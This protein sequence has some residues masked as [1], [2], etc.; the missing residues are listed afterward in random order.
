[1]T[2]KSAA[3]KSAKAW[4]LG[5]VLPW[6]LIVAG[7][8]GVVCAFVITM[9]KFQILKDP[10]YVVSCDINPVISCGSVMRSDQAEAFGFPNPIIGLIGFPVLITIGVAMLAGATFKRWFWIV[11]QLGLVFAVGFVHWLFFEA[12]YRINALCPYCIAVWI[13]SIA[14]FWYVL[15]YNLKTKVITVPSSW[16]KSISFIQKHHL[17]I[18]VLWYLVIAGLILHHFWYYFGTLI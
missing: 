3:A 14:S 18:L 13:V 11:V 5:R 15:V 6:L 10:D 16:Q 7:I 2:K 12:V 8:V 1:M 9:D 17:D 4:T